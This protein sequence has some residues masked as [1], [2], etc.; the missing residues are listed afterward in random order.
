MLIDKSSGA[1]RNAAAMHSRSGYRSLAVGACSGKSTVRDR[2][3]SIRSKMEAP[4]KNGWV[5]RMGDIHG[6]DYQ[7]S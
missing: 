6:A 7:K 4:K 2:L 1:L 3:S 5:L